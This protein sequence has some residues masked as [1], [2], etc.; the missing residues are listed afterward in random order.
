MGSG[1][2]KNIFN[3]SKLA[4]ADN[5]GA[6]LRA[7][8]GTLLTHTDLGGKKALDV[9]IANTTPL[10]VDAI[11]DGIYS[12]GNTDPD[13][14]GLISHVRGAAPA[15]TDQTFRSTGATAT[16]DGVVAANIHG[17]DVNSFLMGYNGTTW[18]RLLTSANGLK[19]DIGDSIEIEVSECYTGV[20][21]FNIAV[22]ATALGTKITTILAGKC[23]QLIKN[24]GDEDVYIKGTQDVTFGDA[25][26]YKLGCGESLDDKYAGD[27]YA[28]ADSGSTVV[29]QVIEYAK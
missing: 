5:I 1:K 8:D 11:I 18:D 17:I 23:G 26:A 25:A 4:C 12:G 19:V 2:V 10:S 20:N 21:P 7:S 14:M 16:S 13:N 22:D 9:N 24:D 28:I 3:P 6:Y 15:D 27:W 29:L